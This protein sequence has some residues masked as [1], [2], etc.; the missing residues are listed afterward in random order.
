MLYTVSKTIGFKIF[1]TITISSFLIIFGYGFAENL[2]DIDNGDCGFVQETTGGNFGTILNNRSG[3]NESIYPKESIRRALLNLK[4]ACCQQNKIGSQT[5]RCKYDK[6]NGFFLNNYP[7]SKFL[8]DHLVDIGLR[9]LDAMEKLLYEGTTPDP[10]GKERR[11]FI[12]T[13]GS[14][15]EGTT[16]TDILPKFKEQR[17]LNINHILPDRE[18]ANYNQ[19]YQ[20]ERT[21]IAGQQYT[22]RPLVNR[23]SNL[24]KVSAYIY[25]YMGAKL[26]YYTRTNLYS[27]CKLQSQDITARNISFTKSIVLKKSNKILYDNINS[28]I[29]NYLSQSRLAKLKETILGIVQYLNVINKKIIKLI[30]TCS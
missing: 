30:E 10:I 12:N 21:S 8:Y 17:T 9:R 19:Q 18:D 2:N 27:S 11:E 28:H 16:P 20:N 15:E 13:K 24:C 25:G 3:Q 29:T 7:D 23:Y 14:Q 5:Q 22:N 6:E 1:I 26:G 4:A